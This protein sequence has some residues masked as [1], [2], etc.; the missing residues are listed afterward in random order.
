LKTEVCFNPVPHLIMHD[1]FSKKQN[2]D[3]LKEAVSLKSKFT[4][5]IIGEGSG[6]TNVKFRSNKVCYYDQIFKDRRQSKLLT[7]IDDVFGKPEFRETLASFQYPMTEFLTTTYHETQVS[8]YGDSGQHYKYHIDRFSNHRRVISF[9][10]Y[11]FK[12]KKTWKGGQFQLTNC[13][14]YLGEP[15]DP[16]A[17]LKTIE[18]ENNMA[19]VF[20]SSI[21]HMV[22]PT[23]SPKSF[24][25]GR[26]SAN[27]WIGFQ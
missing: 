6:E 7:L 16:K 19:M 11:F 27:C 12:N 1:F 14:I 10:Y 20:G 13:P 22:K 17:E 2:E 3:I 4:K 15:I 8:R 9:V 23:K 5:S 21:A 25:N 24:A 18:P 26:F